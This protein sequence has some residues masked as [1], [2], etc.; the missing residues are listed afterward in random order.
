ML[1]SLTMLLVRFLSSGFDGLAVFTRHEEYCE[2][3]FKEADLVICC[4]FNQ[5]SR[6]DK[7]QSL[8][9]ACSCPKVLIDHHVD[10]T[11]F[12]DVVFSFPDMSST[13][14]LSFRIMADLGLYNQMTTDAA[15]CLL[16]DLSRI[17]K[18]LPS[19][20]RI[21]IFT[22]YFSVSLKK[23]AIKIKLYVSRLLKK[24]RSPQTRGLRHCQ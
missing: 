10:P 22:K 21:L 1:W 4:D 18:I 6:L 24:F 2:K 15:T 16:T 19:T 12:A 7:M 5:P 13:C 17:R 3:L 8:L 23:D 14:E 11:P 20:A 9:T